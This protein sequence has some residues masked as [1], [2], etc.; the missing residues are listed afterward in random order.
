MSITISG[1][2]FIKSCITRQRMS[3]SFDHMMKIHTEIDK[4]QSE[5]KYNQERVFRALGVC[6]LT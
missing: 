4:C 1:M 5:I 2:G 6:F 3:D